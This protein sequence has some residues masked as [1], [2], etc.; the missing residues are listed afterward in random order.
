MESHRKGGRLDRAMH[1]DIEEQYPDEEEEE[2]VT[3]CPPGKV[4]H[5]SCE[6]EPC[7]WVCR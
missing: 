7:K 5:W 4:A 2:Y 3:E 6:P 1:K